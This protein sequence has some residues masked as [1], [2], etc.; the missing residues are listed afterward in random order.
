[1]YNYTPLFYIIYYAGR[2]GMSD[3][4][5][6]RLILKDA[7]LQDPL[8]G[9]YWDVDITWFKKLCF[10]LGTVELFLVIACICIGFAVG[11]SKGQ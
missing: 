8:R 10:Y 11:L 3:E 2:G 4:Q 7:Y 5:A 1:M 6:E 9:F